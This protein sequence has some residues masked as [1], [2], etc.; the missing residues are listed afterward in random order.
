MSTSTSIR[1][2]YTVDEQRDIIFSSLVF[3]LLF[4]L[5]KEPRGKRLRKKII[6]GIKK[7]LAVCS[8]KDKYVYNKMLLNTK[9]LPQ[10]IVPLMVI[11]NLKKP[12]MTITPSVLINIVATKHP[13]LLEAWGVTLDIVKEYA[14]FYDGFEYTLSTYMYYNRAM[15]CIENKLNK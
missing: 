3:I 2:V 4:T 15:K 13:A 14:K 11:G 6:R 5:E 8:T 12:V 1:Q 9:D 7:Y 10:E